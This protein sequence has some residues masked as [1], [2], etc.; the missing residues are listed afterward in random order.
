MHGL[1]DFLLLCLFLSLMKLQ[2]TDNSFTEFS[3]HGKQLNSGLLILWC[4]ISSLA[5]LSRDSR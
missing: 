4:S 3:D 2:G 1:Y 5:L